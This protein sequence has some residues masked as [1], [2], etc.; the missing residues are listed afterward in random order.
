M[1]EK[2]LEDL[3]AAVRANTDELVELRQAVKSSGVAFTAFLDEPD[4][5]PELAPAPEKKPPAK[6]KAAK[7]AEPAGPTKDDVIAALTEYHQG[8]GSPPDLLRQFKAKT[9]SDLDPAQYADLIEAAR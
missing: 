5:E 9:V 7:K 8:G 4:V 2:L 6:R 3:A 1:I